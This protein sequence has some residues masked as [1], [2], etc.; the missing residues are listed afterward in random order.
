MSLDEGASGFGLGCRT[1]GGTEGN[2]RSVRV[3]VADNDRTTRT[4][5][6]R[7]L[8]RDV[9]CTV[10]AVEDGLE[11]LAELDRQ[12]YA[13]LLLD[14]SMPVMGGVETL[15]AIRGSAHRSLPV[16]MM[17]SERGAEVVRQAVALG[18]TDYVVKP[19][20]APQT[21]QRLVR[22]LHS[23]RPP[24]G[25]GDAHDG[26]VTL[27]EHVA[28]PVVEGEPDFRQFTDARE[29]AELV[30]ANPDLAA[31]VLKV[32][33]SAYYGL[34]GE[35]RDVK[36]AIAYLGLAQINRIVQVTPDAHLAGLV[37]E[38][39]P[40]SVLVAEGDPGYRDFLMDFFK[41]RCAALQASSGAAALALCLRAAPQLV[42]VGGDLGIINA[43]TLVLK[44]RATSALTN[45][46][47]I[48]IVPT[49]RVADTQQ[50]GLYHSVIARSSVPDVFRGQF[51][52][53]TVP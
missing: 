31:G 38:G 41:T 36:T 42:L 40:D 25:Q 6:K 16:V 1:S 29:V 48:A 9:G 14:V 21:R 23:F 53:L 47:V 17:T 51:E 15:E 45:T 3:L 33:N 24:G 8:T 34:A 7:L 49:S 10:T 52:R 11:A 27:D 28:E 44:I 18:I 12:P 39:E 50:S 26:R 20:T 19:F 35:I 22:V 2:R 46:R 32:V 5:L 30:G 13:A 43:A 37:A 4:L